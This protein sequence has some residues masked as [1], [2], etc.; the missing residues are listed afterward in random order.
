[1][2][3][4]LLLLMALLCSSLAGSQ[5][6]TMPDSQSTVQGQTS[7]ESEILDFFAFGVDP[8]GNSIVAS[9]TGG[10]VTYRGK[11]IEVMPWYVTHWQSQD[12][13][14]ISL[15]NVSQS[16][17]FI[18]NLYLDGSFDGTPSDGFWIFEYTMGTNQWVGPLVGTQRLNHT[19]VK[20]PSI[21]MPR[22]ELFPYPKVWNALR[23]SGPSFSVDAQ[24]GF[25][26]WGSKNF[27]LYPIL[28]L[29]NVTDIDSTWHELWALLSDQ[30]D[31]SYFFAVFYMYPT[32]T[33]HVRN[34][35]MLRLDDYMLFVPPTYTLDAQWSYVAENRQ[36][37]GDS[38]P[39]E[40]TRPFD[41]ELLTLIG[42]V[43]IIVL[44]I[45]AILL[46]SI[47]LDSRRE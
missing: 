32:D 10:F 20:T 17:F 9:R 45:F 38:D 42:S 43:A 6:M 47:R 46:V 2:R 23:A 3:L 14:V 18:I 41:V 39:T 27:T 37:G 24:R 28:N 33:G 5:V 35:L 16:D 29:V 15:V 22:I 11:L 1:M 31:D 44:I 21:T 36:G 25:L 30:A 40:A 13:W 26:T 19:I 12:L 7:K 8:S 4:S 34:G